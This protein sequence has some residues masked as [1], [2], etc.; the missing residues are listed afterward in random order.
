[1]GILEQISFILKD[2][3]ELGLIWSLLAIGV[4]ISF[5]ILD[6]ADLTAEFNYIR[7]FNSSSYDN[8]N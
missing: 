8:P 1:M 7:K 4:F 2:G 6:F 5:R 3:I